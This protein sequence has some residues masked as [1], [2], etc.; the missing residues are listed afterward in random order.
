[1]MMISCEEEMKPF[2]GSH[3]L[4]EKATERMRGTISRKERGWRHLLLLRIIDEAEEEE[5]EEERF[6]WFCF[7]TVCRKKVTYP[8][9]ILNV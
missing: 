3:W 5:E 6:L 7:Y 2:P 8:N 1:M 4:A 9:N